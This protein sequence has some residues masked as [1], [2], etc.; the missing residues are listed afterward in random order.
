MQMYR[1]IS[2]NMTDTEV[3][4]EIINTEAIYTRN[5]EE[6]AQKKYYTIRVADEYILSKADMTNFCNNLSYSCKL[7]RDHLI[8]ARELYASC[9]SYCCADQTAGLRDVP[10]YKIMQMS[11]LVAHSF[12]NI[13]TDEQTMRIRAQYMKAIVEP[14]LYRMGYCGYEMSIMR[15]ESTKDQVKLFRSAQVSHI[16]LCEKQR[17]GDV[18]CTSLYEDLPAP[19]SVYFICE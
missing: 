18:N 2:N 17:N 10:D 7:N 3:V 9:A 14:A 5:T 1:N 15:D 19:H 6:L 11:E 4:C 8:F 12:L 16:T 13:S